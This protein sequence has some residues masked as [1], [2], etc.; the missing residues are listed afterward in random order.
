M[1][2]P[3][4][5]LIDDST[6]GDRRGR[7]RDPTTQRCPDCWSIDCDGRRSRPDPADPAGPQILVRCDS[8]GAT[9]SFADACRAAGVGFSF[10]YAV[11][12]RVRDAVEMLNTTDSWYPAI[13][14]GGGIRDGAWVDEATDLVDMSHWPAGTG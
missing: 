6:S 3:A 10:G 1:P 7:E 8:A 14:S 11:D 12:A 4:R 2:S 9:H 5:D 13:D